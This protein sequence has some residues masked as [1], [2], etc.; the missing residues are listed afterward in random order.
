[1]LRL[2]MYKISVLALSIVFLGIFTQTH[3]ASYLYCTDENGSYSGWQDE[4]E[5]KDSAGKDKVIPDEW[6]ASVHFVP[7]KGTKGYIYLW[8]WSNG[9]TTYGSHPLLE[10]SQ[11]IDFSYHPRDTARSLAKAQRF[12]NYLKSFC[13]TNLPY[14]EVSGGNL[15]L[16][17]WSH[18]FI[19]WSDL[20]ADS[21]VC[22]NWQYKT[23]KPE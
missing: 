5:I 3:A 9:N 2:L 23:G 12:C 20:A 4:F 18:I 13:P 16:S 14:L 7:T 22:P 8:G 17:W 6:K 21:Y 10:V 11:W 19:S 1:M 15:S